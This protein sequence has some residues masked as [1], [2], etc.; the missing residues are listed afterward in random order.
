MDKTVLTVEG[1]RQL[2]ER[3]KHLKEVERPKNVQEIAE[4]RAHGDLSENAEY[5]AAKERQGMLEAQTR[6]IEAKLSNCEVIDPKKLSGDRV[7]FGATVVL[8]NV[9]TDEQV[10]YQI[11]G[12]DEADPGKGKINYTSPVARGLMGKR[13]GDSVQVRTPGGVREYEILEVLFA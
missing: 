11:V 6:D 9:E 2:R 12:M 10:R 7:V 8:A 4:A 1:E 13:V 3:L 5:H